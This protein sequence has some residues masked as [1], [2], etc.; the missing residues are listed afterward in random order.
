MTVKPSLTEQSAADGAAVETLL[1][2][3]F[4][5][6]RRTKT[7]YRLREGSSPLPH[8]SLVIREHELGLVGAI[9]FWPLSVGPAE[10]PAI[11]LGPLAVHPGRQRMGIGLELMREGIARA[12]AAGHGLIILIGDAP[13]YAREG[14]VQVPEGQ[15]QVPGPVD[16]KRL[17]YLELIPRALAKTMG[18]ALPP[19]RWREINALR[20]PT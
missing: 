2:L 13:Y 10:T 6:S 9:S 19:W 1:D 20:A 5:P 15:I 18:L 12:K 17:L 7:S 8:L 4:G 14:F 16:P 3:S 11:M